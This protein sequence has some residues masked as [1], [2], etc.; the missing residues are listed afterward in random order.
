MPDP[1]SIS[2]SVAGLVGL[3]LHGTRLLFDD[4]NNIRDAPQILEDLQT[5]LTSVSSSL[6]SLEAIDESQ[7]E[8]L[9]KQVCD[10][11]K[12]AISKCTSACDGFRGDLQRWTKRS[13]DGKLSWRDKTNIGFFKERR[14]KAMAKQLQSCKLT[15]T[16]VVSTATL[17]VRRDDW[18][19][20]CIPF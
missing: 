13:R 9:G 8:L 14:I 2:A 6:A 16:S 10:Q 7:L 11:S 19:H 12:V 18:H 17:Y 3:A 5:D 15:L 20:G 1:L 4:V